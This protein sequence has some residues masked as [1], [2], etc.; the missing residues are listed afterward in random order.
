[1]CVYRNLVF[2]SFEIFFC[3]NFSEF[4]NYNFV[5]ALKGYGVK[6]TKLEGTGGSYIMKMKATSA[7]Q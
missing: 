2:F 5:E 3:L 1:M 7:E 6:E 4:C